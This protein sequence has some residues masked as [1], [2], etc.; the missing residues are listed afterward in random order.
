M[1]RYVCTNGA[2]TEHSASAKH[3]RQRGEDLDEVYQWVSDEVDAILGSLEGEMQAVEAL[4]NMK[5]E[6]EVAA[7]LQ[8]LFE[9]FRVPVGA[10]ERITAELV[11]SDDISAYGVMQAVTEAAN[12]TE[13]S[14]GEVARLMSVGGSIPHVLGGR[15]PA[16]HR[17]QL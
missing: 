10:R 11:E 17:L 7:T 5:L 15:C 9:Q 4:T 1:F 12:D 13:L 2:T 16:C 6:G 3:R 14:A 8:N